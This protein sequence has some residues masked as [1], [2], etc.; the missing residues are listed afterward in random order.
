MYRR[1]AM[2]VAV[3]VLFIWFPMSI[4]AKTYY[5][6]FLYIY[7]VKFSSGNKVGEVCIV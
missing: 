4:R 2:V 6:S 5:V 7:S 3:V 1:S